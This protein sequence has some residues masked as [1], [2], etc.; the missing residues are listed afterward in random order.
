MAKR[1]SSPTNGEEKGQCRSV[2]RRVAHWGFRGLVGSLLGRSWN[3]DYIRVR[4]DA[5]WVAEIPAL[6]RFHKR[7]VEDGTV[8]SS[9]EEEN[10]LASSS[11]MLQ[12]DRKCH[13]VNWL[14]F[15][16]TAHV[17]ETA[18]VSGI[19]RDDA[20]IGWRCVLAYNRVGGG[21]VAGVRGDLVIE[22]PLRSHRCQWR[23]RPWSKTS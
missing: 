10:K 3:Q 16:R 8:F 18:A 4:A 1:N 22:L 17:N 21:R 9:P 14:C 11:S 7:R 2:Q 15:N 20:S 19:S 13:Q 23:C 5:C 6:L 12:A